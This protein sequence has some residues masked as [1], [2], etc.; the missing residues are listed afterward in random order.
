M[1]T[2]DEYERKTIGY[3]TLAVLAHAAA[4]GVHS[5]AH[6]RV[7]VYAGPL[8]NLF[9]LVV[10]MAAPLVAAALFRTR[11]RRAAALVLLASMA[12]SLAFG[13]YNHFVA[14]SPDH[15]LHVPGPEGWRRVFQVSSVVLALTEV[16][17]VGVG[18]WA[19]GRARA[20]GSP[21]SEVVTPNS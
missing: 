3:A 20:G 18:A 8:G 16:A 10:V 15:V 19:L 1:N 5:L 11:A 12:G 17:G 7:G 6:T 14:V 2:L 21:D 13:V 9:I 4:V